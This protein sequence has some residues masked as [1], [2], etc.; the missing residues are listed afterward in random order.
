MGTKKTGIPCYDKADPDEPLFVLRGQ[1]RSSPE[2]VIEWI[3]RNI[4]SCPDA[5]LH[6]ALDAAIAMT[7]YHSPNLLAGRKTAD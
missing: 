4:A 3:K 5:K 1:D 7:R 2:V 6:E